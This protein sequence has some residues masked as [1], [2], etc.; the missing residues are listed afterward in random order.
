VPIKIIG[1]IKFDEACVF[2]EQVRATFATCIYSQILRTKAYMPSLV[3]FH[4]LYAIK[5]G[6]IH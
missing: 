6:N 2:D 3:K 4:E 5:N 1:A